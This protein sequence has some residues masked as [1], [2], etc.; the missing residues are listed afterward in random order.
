MAKGGFG[1]AYDVYGLDRY[2]ADCVIGW[3]DD[4]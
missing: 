2:Y 3:L 1:N 4:L